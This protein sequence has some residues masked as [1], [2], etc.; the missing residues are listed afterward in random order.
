[1]DAQ[2]IAE[3]LID[4]RENNKGWDILDSMD[5]SAGQTPY[6]AKNLALDVL[7]GYVSTLLDK[8]AT[9]LAE[10]VACTC[11][12]TSGFPP[13]GLGYGVHYVNCPADTG[14]DE[15]D[16]EDWKKGIQEY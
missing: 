10:E 6:W 4:A 1:M 2:E 7:D 14:E 8:L 16:A 9:G 12:T 11:A 15:F 3:I 5:W 13:S